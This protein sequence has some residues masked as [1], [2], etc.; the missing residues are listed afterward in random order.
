MSAFVAWPGGRVASQ[1]ASA[2]ITTAITRGTS[3]YGERMGARVDIA[4]GGGG[5][6]VA[7]G[8]SG[9]QLGGKGGA[10]EPGSHRTQRLKPVV[11]PQ[12]PPRR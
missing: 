11:E 6:A 2:T 8:S 4:L 7:T 1:R 9:S 10:S 3:R 5:V 12:C